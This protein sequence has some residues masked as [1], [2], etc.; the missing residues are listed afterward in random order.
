LEAAAS[1]LLFLRARSRR[2]GST[3]LNEPLISVYEAFRDRPEEFIALCR[4]IEPQKE[5]EPTVKSKD[6]SKEGSK[7]YNARLKGVFEKFAEDE[8]MDPA[9][10]Y[11]YLNRTVWG[12][13]V[14]YDPAQR[15]RLYFSNPQGWNMTTGKLLEQVAEHIR[16]TRITC[17]TY[18]V[19]PI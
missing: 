3:T 18:E 4:E 5:G 13:R 12:G 1:S 8:S 6:T 9:L 2:G 19:T 14:T 15:S 17:D 16:G 11:Y 7:E 10:R